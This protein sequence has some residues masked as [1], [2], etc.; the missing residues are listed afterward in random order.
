VDY[1]QFCPTFE[2]KYYKN[3]V[4]EIPLICCKDCGR[5]FVLVII[6]LI[7]YLWYFWVFRMNMSSSIWKQSN[8]PFVKLLMRGLLEG[9]TMMHSNFNFN[10][11]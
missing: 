7:F 2:V 9:K 11:R 8:V 6:Y 4:P 1:S 5:F 3:M 10:R